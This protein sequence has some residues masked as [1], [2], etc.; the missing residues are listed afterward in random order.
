[1][2]RWDLS[3]PARG[4]RSGPQVLFSTPEARAV[5]I[6][7]AVD[8][9]MGDHGVRERAVLEVVSGSLA[10]TCGGSVVTCDA[11]T[12]AV[13]DPGERRSIRALAPTRLLLMLAPWPGPDH[14][15]PGERDD[16]HALPAHAS[17]PQ[18]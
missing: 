16:P 17:L 10:V 1:M 12:L 13:F 3:A 9:E 18:L 7:L 6:D 8:E 4:D 15:Q 2:Q 14:Y 11:G 5:V